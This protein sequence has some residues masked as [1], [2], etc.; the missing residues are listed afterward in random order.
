VSE[1]QDKYVLLD[2]DLAD[3]NEASFEKFVVID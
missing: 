3:F 2:E 1:L